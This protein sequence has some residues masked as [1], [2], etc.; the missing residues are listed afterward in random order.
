MIYQVLN[1]TTGSTA[2]LAGKS[3]LGGYQLTAGS[4]TAVLTIYDNTAGSGTV[5]GKASAL[6]GTSFKN[7]MSVIANKGIYAVLSG[8]GASALIYWR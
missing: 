6:L 2:I 7:E 5:I 4:D 8:T 3:G 1:I